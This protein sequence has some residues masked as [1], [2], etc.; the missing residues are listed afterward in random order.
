MPTY[1]VWTVGCQMNVSDSERLDS[2]LEKLGLERVGQPDEA[3]LVV[4]N[5]C[6]VRQSA[7]DTATGMLGKLGRAKRE[8]P[9]RVIV[10]MGCMV[11]PDH[12]DLARRFPQVDVWARP[13]EFAVV[14]EAAGLRHGLSKRC[15]CV[16]LRM[17]HWCWRRNPRR[18]GPLPMPPSS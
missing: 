6:V 15:P 10:V 3:D 17:A 2:G 11:G 14:I 8:N 12:S 18:T 9:D 1:H 13:Q 5:T 16:S 4:L 7:E